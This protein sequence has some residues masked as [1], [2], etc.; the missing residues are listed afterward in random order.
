M[1]VPWSLGGEV[2][3]VKPS[4]FK[5]SSRCDS[6]A[7]KSVPL[8]SKCSDLSPSMKPSSYGAF[9]DHTG[10]VAKFMPIIRGFLRCSWHGLQRRNEFNAS[11][12]PPP[13][14]RVGRSL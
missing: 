2:W 3:T 9:L 13:V 7:L 1:T 6:R 10:G 11:S 8:P 5:Y 4:D 12:L 14:R